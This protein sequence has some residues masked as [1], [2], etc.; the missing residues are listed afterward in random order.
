MLRRMPFT[1]V[2]AMMITLITAGC[3]SPVTQQAEPPK[4]E[5][6][7]SPQDSTEQVSKEQAPWKVAQPLPTT[8]KEFVEYPVG[9]FA[10]VEEIQ[11][12]AEANAFFANLPKL[13]ENASDEEITQFYAYMYSLLKP[14]YSD[15]TKILAND[16]LAGLPNVAIPPEMQKESF[17]VEII[18]DS[19]GSMANKLDG[20]T[21]MELAKEAIKEFMSSLPDQANVGLRVYGHRGTG[22]E[23][24]K[25]MSC[26]SNELIYEIKP[27]NGAK[28]DQSLDQIKPAGWTP[29]AKA[30][31]LAQQDLAKFSGGKNRNIIFIVSDGIETC[32]GNP[33]KAA[34]ALK[35]S[36][37]QP[38]VNI[39]GFDLDSEGQA[40]LK[41]VAKAAGGTYTDVRNQQQ[42]RE[43]FRQKREE[44]ELW[45]N[46]YIQSKGKALEA[47]GDHF[48]KIM[49]WR[50]TY[51]DNMFTCFAGLLDS[52]NILRQADKITGE[53]RNKLLDRYGEHREKEM[54]LYEE[55]SDQLFELKDKTFE[56]AV[57]K[58][59]SIFKENRGNHS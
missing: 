48:D 29:L 45:F 57:Q 24:S 52:I 43:Q 49:E 11:K 31:E 1:V 35:N 33:V 26:S 17:N 28:L 53:Q 20:E 3:T 4:A 50:K 12:N 44:A 21:R 56:E 25:Q 37:I 41:A 32:G 7:V 42:L 22:S 8:I 9:P 38:V 46:W 5:Q 14:Q 39:I 16:Q 34:E 15:P 18:L 55:T 13:P 2:V 6:P 58:I 54:Q 19:S 59:E 51:H 23:A 30:I 10:G 27:F 47:R 36:N 40:Q